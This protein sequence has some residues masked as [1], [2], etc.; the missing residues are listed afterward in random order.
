MFD[1]NAMVFAAVHAQLG[2]SVQPFALVKDQ[3]D[4]GKLALV[5]ALDRHGLGYYVVTRPGRQSQNLVT[6]IK[7]LRK[8]V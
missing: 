3:I 6:F 1:T 2:L 4:D 7:W 5:C 8:Q